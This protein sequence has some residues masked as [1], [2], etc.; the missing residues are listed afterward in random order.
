MSDELGQKHH[1]VSDESPKLHAPPTN[2]PSSPR[3]GLLAPSSSSLPQLHPNLNWTHYR[4][5]L[6]VSE[7]NW[8]NRTLERQIQTLG[9]DRRQMPA[10]SFSGLAFPVLQAHPSRLH[11]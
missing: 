5:L 10:P 6:K 1:A 7:A 2:S 9:F 8:S 4:H 11:G 3:S